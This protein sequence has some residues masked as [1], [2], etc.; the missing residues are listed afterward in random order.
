MDAYYVYISM[1]HTRIVA[2][3]IKNKK[4]VY[5]GSIQKVNK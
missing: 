2:I 1:N 5:Y 4:G 3:D